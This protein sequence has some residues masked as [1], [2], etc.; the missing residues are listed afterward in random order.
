VKTEID[1]GTFV[2]NS[3]N[4]EQLPGVVH[5]QIG[6]S[7]KEIWKRLHHSGASLDRRLSA[8]MLP[9]EESEVNEVSILSTSLR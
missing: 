5:H 1:V 8:S 3:L 2:T 7:R 4:V 9:T 6:S